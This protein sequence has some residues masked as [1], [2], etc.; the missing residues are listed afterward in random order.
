MNTFLQNTTL[1][2]ALAS[3]S[4]AA[5]AGWQ[6]D[7]YAPPSNTALQGLSSN[8]G[9]VASNAAGNLLL[10]PS[11]GTFSPIG[12]NSL[13]A[14]F[15]GSLG[16][17]GNGLTISGS[18]TAANGFNQAAR[19]DVASGTWTTLG[20]LGFNSTSGAVGG[21][22]TQSAANGISSDGT[23][24]V[25]QAY[26]NTSGTTGV[27]L[28]PVVFRNGQVIDLNPTGTTQSGKALATNQDG[29]VV[30][31]YASNSAIGS[32]WKWNGSSY[33]AS[34]PTL[35]KP[36]TST[37]VS[38]R[39]DVVSS[40]GVWVAGG[41][42]NGLATNYAPPL[43]SPTITYSPATLWNTA[44]NTGL[45]IPFDHVIDTSAGGS[46]VIRNMKANVQGVSDNGIVI[47]TFSECLS[48]TTGILQ[49]D[50]WIY[51]AGTGVTLS[52]DSYLASLGLAL[53]PTQHVWQLNAMS[54]DGS[55]ISGLLY[56]SATST[57]SSFVLHNVSAVP[58]PGSW[59]LFA[60]AL[61]LLMRRLRQRQ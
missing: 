9:G 50:T 43:T 23:V 42:V 55:A 51:N 45:L 53:A 52:F 57:T 37:N 15:A 60:L 36:G 20:S 14:G 34:T 24:V 12:G 11:P 49:Q 18:A 8:A 7:T 19:Y 3:A 22:L 5:Q 41:S 61:P 28:H 38:L 32:I 54:A 25:G 29:S 4:L 35:L 16:I 17:S 10:S 44:T 47:G 31:G 59:A 2:A 46:D 6:L 56:D 40:N 33:A 58:E 27:R 30:V 13:A 39:A 26:F 1:A 21:V 48:C